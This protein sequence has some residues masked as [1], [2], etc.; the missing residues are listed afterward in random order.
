MSQRAKAHF[1]RSIKREKMETSTT[2]PSYWKYF[3]KFEVFIAVIPFLLY[4]AIDSP[5]NAVFCWFTPLAVLAYFFY[6]LYQV[7]AATLFPSLFHF[8]WGNHPSDTLG[9]LASLAIY[10][11]LAAIV[12]LLAWSMARRKYIQEK[13]ESNQELEPT[14]TPPPVVPSD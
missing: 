6:H 13:E 2:K 8:N 3:W 9:K 11:S 10:A 12:A 4:L 5:L 14:R 1:R 7:P